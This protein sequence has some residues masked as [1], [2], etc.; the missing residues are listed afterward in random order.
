MNHLDCAEL[1][2]AELVGTLEVVNLEFFVLV[3]FSGDLVDVCAAG[4]GLQEVIYSVL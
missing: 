4:Y 1:I 3:G 2:L